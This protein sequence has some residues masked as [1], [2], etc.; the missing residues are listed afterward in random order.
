M[1]DAIVV[2]A[3]CAGSPVAMQL[4]RKGWSV[5]LVD[6]NSFPSDAMS[7][8]FI[9]PTGTARLKRWGLLDEVV[10]SNA[11]RI[12]AWIFDFG[13]ATFAGNPPPKDGVGFTH[14]PR[15]TVL[16]D[17]LVRAARRAGVEVRE[18]F[19]VRELLM[20]NGRVVGIRG[21]SR[22]GAPVTERARV[23]VG[24]DGRN[25][26]VARAV[27]A[28]VYKEHP[29]LCCAYYTYWADV[30]IGECELYIRDHRIAI[31]FPTND[32]QVCT[33]FEWPIAEIDAVRADVDGSVQR[34]LELSPKLAAKIRRGRRVRH[35]VGTGDLPNYFRRSHGPGW[36]LA[37]DA[38]HHK[39]PCGGFGISDAFR[40][41]DQLADALDEGLSGRAPLD[42]V[43]AGYERARDRMAIPTFELN[44][45]F[46][47]LHPSPP[48]ARALHIA[49]EASQADAD[50]FAGA[51]LGTVPLQEFFSPENIDR[52]VGGAK[53]APRLAAGGCS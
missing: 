51:I 36:A 34:L 26:F 11:P 37:G 4:A 52:I 16:D 10:A 49:L 24:A 30:P 32:G 5:L 28:E 35:Y 29:V 20:E 3:R 1:Y 41:A 50:R 19:T 13:Y 9:H 43:L 6:K 44:C 14:C 45:D 31:V 12:G 53:Q 8:H 2:G 22:G 21:E 17:I 33:F 18:N 40:D 38:G 39:D 23:V 47:S 15:R 25:S 7:T 27:G 46:A 42:D 48:G